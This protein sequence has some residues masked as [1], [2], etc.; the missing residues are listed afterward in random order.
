[1]DRRDDPAG[2]QYRQYYSQSTDGGRTWAPNQPVA[3]AGAVPS[4]FIGDY[5]GIAVNRDNT[6]V[7]PIWT[8]MRNGQQAFTDRG[9]LAPAPTPT[10]CPLVFNDVQ[11]GDYFYTAVQY[12]TCRGI[13]SG[14]SDGT[15]RPANATSRAQMVKIVVGGFGVPPSMPPPAERTFQDVP[16]DH[17]FYAAIEAAV[18]AGI[19]SG[20]TCG[21]RP[22]EPCPG[23]YF[24]PYN[25]VTR[26]QLT[27]I[28]ALAGRWTLTNPPAATFHDLSAESPFYTYIEA[29]YC[30][31]VIS[32]YNDGTF[33]PGAN[34]TRGQT[35]KIVY[36]ALSTATA[37]VP[38]GA[39]P[40][41]DQALYDQP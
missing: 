20:Y 26:G 11:P 34:A 6:L 17:P 33:R 31:G 38:P 4:S 2:F 27:K 7:L 30:R 23:L 24:R 29:A 16:A 14:Y 12:L 37:C 22:D 9:Q 36:N 3:D 10:P 18:H 13:I 5:N 35:A 32:G 39:Q 21:T 28:V 1:M 8:D 19:V 15:F 41:R 25:N 40:A